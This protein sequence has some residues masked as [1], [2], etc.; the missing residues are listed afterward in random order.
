MLDPNKITD[1]EIEFQKKAAN[2]GDEF[3]EKIEGIFKKYDLKVE[4]LDKLNKKRSRPDFF[5]FLKNDKD[6]G[7]ICECKYISSAGVIDNGKYHVSML[8]EK[9]PEKGVFQYNSCDAKIASIIE[10]ALS[11]Y[12]ALVKDKPSCQKFPF[13]IVLEFDFFAD[14]F[15]CIFNFLSRYNVSEKEKE[16]ISAIMRIEKN[17]EQK[18]EFKNWSTEELEKEI[19]GEGKKKISPES[20]ESERFK[21]L[22]N[23]KAKIPFKPKDFL[24]KLIVLSC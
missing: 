7:F 6:K 23:S 3:T 11:Q 18:E 24:R 21:V 17:I 8:D 20:K 9:L 19:K 2:E 10:K 14:R 15:D 4:K 1:E 5:V 16:T 13:V 22:L 12:Q